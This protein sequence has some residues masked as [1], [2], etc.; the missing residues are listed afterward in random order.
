MDLIGQIEA[1]FLRRGAQPYEAGGEI[2]GLSAQAHALQCA[3]LA[4]WAHADL[5][6]VAAALLHDLGQ[7]IDAPAEAPLVDSGHELRALDLLRGGFG[8]AVL[9]PIRLHVPAAR[10]LAASD[11]AGLAMPG[12]E[13]MNAEQRLLFMARPWA[14]QALQLVRWDQLARH[15]GKRTPP[16]AYYLDLLDGL[17]RQPRQNSRVLIA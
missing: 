12:A 15:P 5:A 11:A 13:R 9:E 4:E 7:L 17:L 16:L 8:P 3:Q 14:P 2:R 10:Y 1:L 6:Q